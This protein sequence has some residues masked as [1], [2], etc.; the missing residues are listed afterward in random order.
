MR[1]GGL[2]NDDYR[3]PEVV[4]FSSPIVRAFVVRRISGI[5][6][7]L[8]FCPVPSL[9]HQKSVRKLSGLCL[10]GVVSSNHYSAVK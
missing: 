8:Q 9:L 1:D 10:L 7:A 2:H 6:E 3:T 4:D 5:T